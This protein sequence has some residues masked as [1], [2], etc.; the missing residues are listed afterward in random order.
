MA[1]I[2]KYLIYY[3]IAYVPTAERNGVFNFYNDINRGLTL[4]CR[5]SPVCAGDDGKPSGCWLAAVMVRI[6]RRENRDDSNLTG[7]E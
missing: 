6:C 4:R 3:Y 7:F 1:L 2:N 5:N